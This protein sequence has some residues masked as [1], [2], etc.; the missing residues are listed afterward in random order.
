GKEYDLRMPA[1]NVLDDPFPEGQ[2]LGVRIV[3]A[4]YFHAF[5]NPVEQN[6]PPRLP[7]VRLGG[8]RVEVDVDDVLVFFWRVLRVLD[9]AVR[10]PGKPLRMFREPGMVR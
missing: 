5:G 6:V 3:D 2:G 8:G 1:A 10:P 9:A 4:T 7:H